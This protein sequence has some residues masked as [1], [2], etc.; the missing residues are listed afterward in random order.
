M[1][2]ISFPYIYIYKS[3]VFYLE[4]TSLILAAY[5]GHTG[6]VKILIENG[7]DVNLQDNIGYFNN[8]WIELE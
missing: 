7:A 1:H 8:L 5:Q 6:I 2:N 4:D 3:N